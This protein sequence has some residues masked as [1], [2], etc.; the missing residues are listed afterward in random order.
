MVGRVEMLGG[1][2]ILGIVAAANM[3]TDQTDPQVHPAIS[4]SQTILTAI[5]TWRD[6]SYLVEMTTL[7]CHSSL[8]PF[9]F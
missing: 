3:A 2:L 6:L 5:R 7:L 1:M 4:D 8:F 9:S